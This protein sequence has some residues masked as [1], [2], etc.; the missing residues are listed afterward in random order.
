[1]REQFLVFLTIGDV[2][3]HLILLKVALVGDGAVGKTALRER[4]IGKTFD[5]TY[6]MTIGADFATHMTIIDG[7]ETKFQIWDLAGQ[8]RFSS[9]RPAFYSGVMGCIVVYDITRKETF[10][11][12]PLWIK[13]VFKYSGHGQVPVIL[14]GNKSDLR[15]QVPY[16]I[17][18]KHGQVLSKEISSILVK[19]GLNC[20]YFD[21]S[22]KTGKNVTEAFN[23]LGKNILDHHKGQ[24]IPKSL[25]A[26][27]STTS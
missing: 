20:K 21:T 1:M 3:V 7:I 8:T 6:Q 22:A 11:N 14:L 27:I 9:V 5:S 10:D 19:N 15:E 16:P 4:Y 25:K 18:P 13:E 24:R 17:M 26:R 12:T 23:E 2:T